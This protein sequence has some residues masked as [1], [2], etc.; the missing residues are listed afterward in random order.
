MTSHPPTNGLMPES[1][2]A[3]L[4]ALLDATVDELQERHDLL[5]S[6]L[7]E[8][9]AKLTRYRKLQ[10]V[11]A[12]P[13][14]K[15]AKTGGA[16]LAP[17]CRRS[18]RED[19]AALPRPTGRSRAARSPRS[20]G[21]SRGAVDAASRSPRRRACRFAGKAT[22][23]R[24]RAATWATFPGGDEVAADAQNALRARRRERPRT[25]RTAAGR[26]RPGRAASTADVA[27]LAGLKTKR[28]LVNVGVRLGYLRKIGMVERD[29]AT[30]GWFLTATGG[31]SWLVDSPPLP[32]AP[33]KTS[34]GARP[35]RRPNS[36][37]T[38]Q[39]R[40]RPTGH[41]DAPPVAAL[42]A[43][44]QRLPAVAAPSVSHRGGA[45]RPAHQDR[46]RDDP[47]ARAPRRGE[48]Q[49]AGDRCPYRRRRPRN[50]T[51]I[52]GYESDVDAAVDLFE[53]MRAA[54]GPDRLDSCRWWGRR[55]A[56]D[57]VQPATARGAP[58]PRDAC[59]LPPRRRP[60]RAAQ[61]GDPRPAP[62]GRQASR[63]ARR[64]QRSPV[65]RPAD[66]VEDHRPPNAP[67]IRL[68][69]RRRHRH[70][71]RRILHEPG[72]QTYLLAEIAGPDRPLW[73]GSRRTAGPGR[74]RAAC[75][76][77]GPTTPAATGRLMRYDADGDPMTREVGSTS[78]A[79]PDRVI[80]RTRVGDDVAGISTVWIGLD[81]SFGCG[82][83]SDQPDHDLRRRAR[84]DPVALPEPARR[85]R[86]PRPS[87]CPSP[88]RRSSAL[89]PPSSRCR[90]PYVSPGELP[91]L[92]PSHRPP[93]HHD[94]AHRGPRRG[95]GRRRLARRRHP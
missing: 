29:P 25:T 78:S 38:A 63:R 49:R 77:T 55:G 18:S 40:R 93:R 56:G 75:S 22:R 45:A 14:P 82:A 92:P 91:A 50:G 48:R 87:R 6:E 4:V 5:K 76:P 36:S 20:I 60:P 68:A 44:P 53:H 47:D 52:A 69:D 72:D 88:R 58:V 71:R 41:D 27:D 16:A 37:A 42:L 70:P 9:T 43:A 3:Q 89:I 57:R 61:L 35:G 85:A 7:A 33:S 31:R 39:D 67:P 79:L 32:A 74:R 90:P 15:P 80:A 81:Y 30:H 95:R 11:G 54:P 8:I 23:P 51:S 34:T 2:E 13:A 94:V 1:A 19:R 21:V 83:P 86:R 26:R 59:R 28:P 73:T 64:R 65:L 66:L 84:P 10:G 46:R 62:V 17:P 12:A 24:L